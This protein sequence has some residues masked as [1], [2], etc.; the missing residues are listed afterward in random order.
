VGKQSLPKKY[1]TAPFWKW[2]I[3]KGDPDDMVEEY[4]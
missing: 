2:N 1:E 3:C 4:L